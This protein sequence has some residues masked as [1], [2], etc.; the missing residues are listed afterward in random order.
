VTTSTDAPVTTVTLARL[1]GPDVVRAVALIG[2][3][4]MNYHG[5]LIL[6]GDGRAGTGWWE[7]VFNPWTGP[8]STRFAATFVLVAG[9]SVTLMTTRTVER[10]RIDP[11]DPNARRAVTA[12]RWR[13]VRRGTLLYLGGLLLDEVWRGTIIPYYGIMFV[14]AAA[15]F[16]WRTRW[17]VLTGLAA[18]VAGA[19]LRW[20]RFERE[21]D[22]GSTRWLTD[23][24]DNSLREHVFGITVNGTHPLL[25]WLAFFCAGIVLG[26]VLR[27][28]WW[29]PATI[30]VGFTLLLFT[31]LAASASTS[32]TAHIVLSIRPLDRSVV[33][34]TSALG[35]A[36][37]AYGL[38]DWLATRCP[39]ATDP[40]RRA[41][42]WSLTLYLLHVA[43]FLLVV[44]H[45]EWIEPAG[46]GVA[47]AF[48][49]G[50]WVV[51]ITLAGTGSRRVGLGPAERIYRS[52]GG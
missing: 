31:A 30:T 42:Q 4:V 25:P 37:I 34:V 40:L 48:A 7:D 8:L 9:V 15:M 27:T 6:R 39:V 33:Y 35:T 20:W 49:L 16:T 10:R 1:P 14:L 46:V 28:T 18:A 26:R 32:G 11:T 41:G 24:P 19:A 51:G 43:V 44:D 52:F 47:V 13:L 23:P 45:L 5:Y 36:L 12:M 22:G 29:R 38:L 21:R 2:V 3:V 50:F 17:I